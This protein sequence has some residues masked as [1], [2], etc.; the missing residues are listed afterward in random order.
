MGGKGTGC[1]QAVRGNGR[2]VTYQLSFWVSFA[3]RRSVP[4]FSVRRLLSVRFITMSDATD[5][6]LRLGGEGNG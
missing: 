5:I 6:E 1:M 3:M 4:S 2:D